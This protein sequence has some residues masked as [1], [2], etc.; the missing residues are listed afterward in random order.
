MNYDLM[1]VN[2]AKR[3]RR[4]N[5]RR[6]KGTGPCSCPQCL[7][8]ADRADGS[9]NLANLSDTLMDMDDENLDD[10]DLDDFDDDF[11]DD[12]FDAADCNNEDFDDDD[13]DVKR[14][15]RMKKRRR[16]SRGSCNCPQCLM[17]AELK[18]DDLDDFDDYGIADCNDEDE[19]LDDDNDY[20]VKRGRHKRR[21]RNRSL[22]PCSSM[23]ADLEDVEDYDDEDSLDSFIAMDDFDDF[24]DEDDDLDDDDDFDDE[25]DLDDEDHGDHNFMVMDDD[26]D[27]EDDLD[28]EYYDDDDFMA[29]DNENDF[30]DE[31]DLD[32]EDYDDAM[33]EDDLNGNVDFDWREPEWGARKNRAR[34]KIPFL[35]TEK[36]QIRQALELA[37]CWARRVKDIFDRIWNQSGEYIWAKREAEWKRI[38]AICDWFGTES[39]SPA[40]IRR[41]RR[42]VRKIERILRKSRIRF[43]KIQYQSGRRS[44]QCKRSKTRSAYTLS[45]GIRK[46][47]ICPNFFNK[48]RKGQ[49]R[50]IIHELVHEIGFC[51]YT[52]KGRPACLK[53]GVRESKDILELARRH[54]TAARKNPSSYSELYEA[55]GGRCK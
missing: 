14:R 26:F 30:D 55:L 53:A 45:G 22:I 18:D 41:T 40:Q 17:A 16:R 28:D 44:Y 10:E 3:Q 32:D 7:M 15:S 6:S 54:P 12:N 4:R 52:L 8:A 31:D 46:I 49:A 29:M 37:H 23:T 25:D 2:D 9:F 24:D 11:D 5:Q 51:H 38:R 20:D 34:K 47:F 1:D 42:R 27:D 39:L 19:D 36:R 21:R 13:Y 33:D 43:V 35:D 50:T 48:D